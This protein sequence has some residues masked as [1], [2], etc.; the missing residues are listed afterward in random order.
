MT[1]TSSPVIAALLSLASLVACSSGAKTT[2][3]GATGNPAAGVGATTLGA[4]PASGGTAAVNDSAAGTSSSVGS[5]G[6][7]A[8]VGG[9]GAT[10]GSA[11]VGGET[12]PAGGAATVAAGAGGMLA[13]RAGSG[14]AAGDA[15]A[16]GTPGDCTSLP[17]VTDYTAPGPFADAKLFASVG[18]SSNY[19]MYR[20]DSSLGKDG[21]KHPIATW[22]NGIM[23]T[24]DQYKKLLTLVAS[25]GFVII[26]CDDTKVERACLNDGMEWLIQQNTADGPL[27][28]KLDVNRE[29]AIGYSWGGGAAIDVSDRPNIKVTVSLHGM[30]PRVSDAFDK[31]HAPLLLT[32]STGDMFV[33]ASGYVTPNYES[34]K[35]QT[36]YGTLMDPN[37]GHLYIVDSDGSICSAAALLGSTFGSCQGAPQEK[38]PTVAWLRYW[39]CGD[40][41]AKDFFFGDDCELCKGHW[42]NAQRKNW[43]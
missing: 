27:K 41:G 22:G 34:S 8:A 19:T 2:L 7:T 6:H 12:D 3:S 11:A 23:T 31:M 43:M 15:S 14:G 32:T 4:T 42:M 38:G 13:N 25:H 1:R 39:A 18:P 40:Q 36:F 26:G 9:S 5:A 21:F 17:P 24:P 35:V 20:P 37:A 28:G 30:P 33:T 16:A 29:V 10:A